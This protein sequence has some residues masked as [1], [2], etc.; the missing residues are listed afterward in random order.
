ML[1]QEIPDDYVIATGEAHS[2]KE[3]LEEVFEYANLDPYKYIEINERLF[4]PHEVPYLLGDNS[5]VKE[6]LGWKP[7]YTF[8]TLAKEMY[9]KDLQREQRKFK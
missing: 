9:E 6:K 4:R 3:F 1:Q 5:K 8:K 2:V 7:H